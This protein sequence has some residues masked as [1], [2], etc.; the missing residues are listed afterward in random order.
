[1][2][3]HLPFAE[4]SRPAHSEEFVGQP[5]LWSANGSLRRL[6]EAGRL[7]AAIFWGPPGSGKT[8]L[9]RIIANASQT[10]VHYLSAV[11]ASVKDLREVFS[12]S[13]ASIATGGKP[14]L[15]F[16][17]EVHRLSKSQQDVLLPV[18]EDGTI[19][20]I[21][22]TT[23]NPSF[24]VNKAI[25]SR[26]L[27]FSFR[28]HSTVELRA[29][30]DQAIQRSSDPL[31]RRPIDADVLDAI[32]DCSDGDA[33]QALKLFEATVAAVPMTGATIGMADLERFRQNLARQFDKDG[34]S[35][36]DI[37]SALIKCIRASQPDAA[38]YYLARLVDGGEDPMFI[39]R[40]LVIAASED[41]GNANPT[42]LLVA[43]AAMQSAHMVGYPEARIILSQAVTYLACSPKSN[44][45]YVAINAAMED[46]A[47]TGSLPVPLGLRNAPTA[48]L[49]KLGYGK[50]Y[51]YAHDD[52]A[53]AA[54]MQYLPDLL[55]SRRYYEPSD[56]GTE[57]Q[58]KQNLDALRR[59]R[60]HESSSPR[61]A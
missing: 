14:H 16:L 18:L 5:E 11:G 7:R 35:H 27:V 8:T 45:A 58:L 36:Y 44:R 13:Q 30:L 9:A 41:I 2:A 48:L 49:K 53:G 55:T 52:P 40:R 51:R 61:D 21:G 1:M 29:I 10:V 28:R 15:V 19:L 26:S 50:E 17:D 56:S 31:V 12:Q 4:S 6:V 32:A 60:H 47:K 25:L 43:T 46:V 3:A 22:A 38:V 57:K 39:A 24:E 54:K 23:E 59:L 37:I 34:E 33:R 20:F 42:A